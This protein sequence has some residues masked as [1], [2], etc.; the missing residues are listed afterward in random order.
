M[1]KLGDLIVR[2]KLQY[3]DYEKGL[4]EAERIFKDSQKVIKD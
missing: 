3:K 4:K 1:G 2:L